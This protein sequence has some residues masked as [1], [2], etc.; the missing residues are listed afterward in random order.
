MWLLNLTGS[1]TLILL[2]LLLLVNA[3]MAYLD[4]LLRL[5]MNTLRDKVKLGREIS[6]GKNKIPHKFFGRKI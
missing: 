3:M 2:L 5:H 4:W 1:Y 6:D